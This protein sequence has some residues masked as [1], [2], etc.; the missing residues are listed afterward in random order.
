MDK[1]GILLGVPPSELR[2]FTHEVC[3]HYRVIM[4]LQVCY[5][6]VVYYLAL[7]QLHR[8]K[9]RRVTLLHQIML[10][11]T[12]DEGNNKYVNNEH[13]YQHFVSEKKIKTIKCT[14][15]ENEYTAESRA[16]P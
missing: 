10:H 2:K 16:R 7:H 12:R 14:R 11:H 5:G 15:S 3:W 8:I 9:Q 13:K 6:V 1:L 4:L